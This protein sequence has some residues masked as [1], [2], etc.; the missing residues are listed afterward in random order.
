VA[1]LLGE[2]AGAGIGLM[3]DRQRL[4]LSDASNEYGPLSAISG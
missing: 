1:S 4:H 2:H 3:D